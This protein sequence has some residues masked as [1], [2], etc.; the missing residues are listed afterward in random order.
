MMSKNTIANIAILNIGDK[1]HYHPREH[2]EGE[3]GIVKEIRSSQNDAVFVVYNC[4]GDWKN[5]QNYKLEH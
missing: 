2:S 4:A 1:V 3:N 5:Y